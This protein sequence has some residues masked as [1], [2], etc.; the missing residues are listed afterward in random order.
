M[1]KMI[2][3]LK[4]FP[5]LLLSV[6]SVLSV[7][8]Q[9]ISEELAYLQLDK[10][11][12]ETGEDLWFKTYVFDRSTLALSGESRTL[13]VEMID[14]KDSLVWQEK[15]P[16]E[17]GIIDGH[18]YVDKNLEPGDYR[19]HAYTKSSFSG[20]TVSPYY[21]KV[22]RVVKNITNDRYGTKVDTAKNVKVL[23]LSFFP[24]G[25]SM[26]DGITAKVAFKVLDANGMPTEVKGELRENGKRIA[27]LES[28][29]DG[30]GMFMLLPHRASRYTVVLGDSTEYSF[31]EVEPSGLS[32]HLHKQTDDFLEFYLSQQKGGVPQKIR[33]EG[34]M[35]GVVYCMAEGTLNEI[36]KVKIP[37]KEFPREGIAEFT[38]YNEA[39]Q[40]MAERLVFLNPGRKLNIEIKTDKKRYGTR[41]N[42]KIAVC[43]S[44]EN[45]NP[46][47]AHLGLSLFDASYINESVPENM[48]SYCMLSTEIKGNIHNPVYYFNE[49]NKGRLLL[50]DLLLLTQG[51]RRYVWKR[52]GSLSNLHTFLSD[53]ITGRQIVGKKRK[54]KE[55][56]NVR[57]LLQ[58][59]GPNAASQFVMTDSFGQF[60]ILPEQMMAL[61]GGY[62]Y[63]KPMLDKDEYKPKIFFDSDFAQADSLRSYC[64]F[65][66][67]YKDIALLHTDMLPMNNPVMSQDSSIL[68]SEVT[69]TGI[70]SR[71]FRD[72]MMGRLDSLAQMRTNSAYLCTSCNYLINYELDYN[73]HHNQLGRCPAKGR[74][75][76]VNGE[77]YEI[78]KFKYAQD[79]T[80]FIVEDRRTVIYQLPM[81][82][83]EELLRMNNI[84]RTKGYY[85]KRE[86]YQPNEVDMQSSI[87]DARNVLLWVPDIIT[88]EQGCAEINFFCSDINTGFIGVIEGT[89]GTGNIGSS[90]CKF[91]VMKS[92]K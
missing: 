62:V 56:I 58:V 78:A 26:I 49:E 34:K 8:G 7:N 24:E 22:I 37:V 31:P 73:A 44:D 82:T 39:K 64:K 52:E 21:P 43:V 89:D 88:D 54:Q 71:V 91:R 17:S 79:G 28:L 23:R 84:F 19:I 50:L 81:Y 68:L 90:H 74:E 72:K 55:I 59:S 20:D 29:H 63:V 92:D 65:Y 18:I 4:R 27:L 51:W 40:P 76:P 25:G 15:Y 53:E 5:V 67:P 38:L 13:F 85:S 61:R 9:N 57:Q 66:Q 83:E 46:V 77:K 2:R 10:S 12:Y 6:I 60:T 16:I 42:G 35:R 87:P 47:R 69:V 41:E 14:R 36:L 32:L 11:I 70:K 1:N 80:H 33:L 75:Q 86:F 30:M 45:G 3:I 48:L